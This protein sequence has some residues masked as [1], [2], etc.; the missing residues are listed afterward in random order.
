MKSRSS[1][2]ASRLL[3]AYWFEEWAWINLQEI[4]INQMF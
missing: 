3:R 1:I 4:D 2:G